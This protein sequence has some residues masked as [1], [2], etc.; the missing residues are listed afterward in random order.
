MASRL[1]WQY[2]SKDLDGGW[3]NINIKAFKKYKIQ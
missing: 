2:K 3:V 1:D